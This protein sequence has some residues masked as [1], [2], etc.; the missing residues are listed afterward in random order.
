MCLLAPKRSLVNSQMR[1]ISRGLLLS[2]CSLL[3]AACGFFGAEPTPTPLPPPVE[4]NMVTFN[5]LGNVERA[6]VEQF[7]ATHPH[8]QIKLADFRAE[9]LSYLTNSTPPDILML[10][11]GEQLD[12][13]ISQNLVTDVT[14]VWQQANLAASYPAAFQRLSERDGKQFFLPLAYAWNAIYYNKQLFAQYNLQPPQTW[15]QLVELCEILLNNGETPFA[16]SGRDPFMAALWIDYLDL[17]LNG[18]EFHRQLSQGQ[19]AYDSEARVRAFFARWQLLVE[20]GYFLPEARNLDGLATLLTLVRNEKLTLSANKAVMALS[21]P[22]F[23]NEV[24][25]NLRSELDFFPFP[26]ID[27]S[28]PVA[29]ALFSIGY[30]IPTNAPHRLEAL[31]FLAF[32]NSA[33]GRAILQKEVNS[34]AGYVP[35]FA[36]ADTPDLPAL[37]KQGL[38][39][40]QSATDL[41][42]PYAISIPQTMFPAIDNLLGQLLADPRRGQPFDLDGALVKLEAA[43][44]K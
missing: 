3:L 29:E 8:I 35:A 27:A 37:S 9:P 7:T 25:A 5:V 30:V 33:E 23:L 19:V 14:D 26:V 44:A 12:A 24:P 41:A 6:L 10:A 4:L 43:R 15:E 42:P 2:L 39:L 13:A 18:A 21:S 31:E 1:T 20:Q 34:S 40:V 22:L 36:R 32:L 17:R 16:V 11:P 28:V 38:S